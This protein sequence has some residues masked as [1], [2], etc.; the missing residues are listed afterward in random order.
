MQQIEGKGE[1]FTDPDPDKAREYF[2]QKGRVMKNKVTSLEKAVE[3]FIQDGKRKKKV[4]GNLAVKLIFQFRERQ[5][6]IIK[7]RGR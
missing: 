4:S 6:N 2:K 7:E 3:S 5:H 1:L